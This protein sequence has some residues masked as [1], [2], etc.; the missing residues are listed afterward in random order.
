MGR[1]VAEVGKSKDEK[2]N[3]L[4][5]QQK[6]EAVAIAD[7][8]AKSLYSVRQGQAGCRRPSG[9]RQDGCCPAG[10]S[11]AMIKVAVADGTKQLTSKH[12]QI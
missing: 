2:Q 10:E 4:S 1:G 6:T 3:G 12:A 5:L 9:Q 8:G 11:I 7:R